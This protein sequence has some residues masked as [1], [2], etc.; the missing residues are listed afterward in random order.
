MV[1]EGW[2]IGLVASGSGFGGS[3]VSGVCEMKGFVSGSN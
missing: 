3:V 1:I 2:V